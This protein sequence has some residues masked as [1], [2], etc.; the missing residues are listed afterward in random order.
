MKGKQN[1]NMDDNY[2]KKGKEDGS[3]HAQE[4]R[5]TNFMSKG[6]SK[7]SSTAGR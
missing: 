4:P 7:A 6:R 5:A 3:I 2:Y 1:I